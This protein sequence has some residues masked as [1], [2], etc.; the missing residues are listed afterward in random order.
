MWSATM[1]AMTSVGP[2]AAKGTIIVI[3]RCGKEPCAEHSRRHEGEGG[4]E[5]EYN[6]LH[7]NLLTLLQHN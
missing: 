4:C 5:R 2:P 1:R 7:Q 3:G 6:F